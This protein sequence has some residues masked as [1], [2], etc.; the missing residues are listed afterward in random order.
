[1]PGAAN[2][3]DS[4][5]LPHVEAAFFAY[6]GDIAAESRVESVEL[7]RKRWRACKPRRPRSSH[8]ETTSRSRPCWASSP[9]GTDL[10][11]AKAQFTMRRRR[12][13]RPSSSRA[14]S[15]SPHASG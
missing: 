8:T 14:G 13:S 7:S 5:I 10:T 6:V 12:L 11:F 1:M 4:V 3:N 15:T 2:I 9:S